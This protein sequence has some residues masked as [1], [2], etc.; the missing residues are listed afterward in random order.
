MSRRSWCVRPCL[1]L[2]LPWSGLDWFKKNKMSSSSLL[3]F[4]L[5]FSRLPFCLWMMLVFLLPVLSFLS[6]LS[7]HFLSSFCTTQLNSRRRRGRPDKKNRDST[8]DWCSDDE[9]QEMREKK[10]NTHERESCEFH[11]R[12]GKKEKERW[13]GKERK[14]RKERS[15]KKA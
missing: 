5:W 4:L 7:L 1:F 14:G 11:A 10:H 15:F 3:S 6:S 13:V 2:T 12:K 8:T 9:S